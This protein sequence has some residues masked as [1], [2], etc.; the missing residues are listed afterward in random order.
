[1]ETEGQSKV[2]KNL[3]DVLSIHD[4]LAKSFG[5]DKA[6][7]MTSEVIHDLRTGVVTGKKVSTARYHDSQC[8][9]LERL[10]NIISY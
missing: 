7:E 5:L 8:V 9:I 3:C 6:R 2:L 1:M 4:H 10:I